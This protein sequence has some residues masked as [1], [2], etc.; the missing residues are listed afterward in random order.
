M[1]WRVFVMYVTFHFLKV[2]YLILLQ[3]A[4]EQSSSM[5]SLQRELEELRE[6]RQ[7]DKERE[8]RRI[9]DDEE[10]IQILRDRCEKLES[11]R[12]LSQ[13]EVRDNQPSAL[14]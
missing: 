5:L 4:E 1:N 6:L 14:D 10:E 3:R 11:E 2:P 8:A 9:Q 12:T 13:S 7:R